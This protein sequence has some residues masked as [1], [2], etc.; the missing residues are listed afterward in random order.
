MSNQDNLQSGY[1]M[2]AENVAEMARLIRNAREISQTIG[3]CPKEITLADKQTILDIA[4]GPGEW[5]IEIAHLLPTSRIMGI[6]ISQIMTRYAHLT[7]QDQQL[8]NTQFRIMDATQPLDFP[9]SSFDL[10]HA[11]LIEGFL[12]RDDWPK[13]LADCF[14]LL[15]PGGVIC[16]VEIDNMGSNTSPA[17]THYNTLF[18]EALRRAGKS[19]TTSGDATGVLAVQARLLQNAGFTTIHSQAHS[20]NYSTGMPAHKTVYENFATMLQLLQPLITH[21][22]LATTEDLRRLRTLALEEMSAETFCGVMI[23][24][25]V[26]GEKPV[27]VIQA[28]TTL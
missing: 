2:D 3:L 14:R 23:L 22:K 17:L 28:Q 7:A 10:I 5:A 19:F 27:Q 20:F 8:L 25:S 13:L 4:C 11:R 26:W 6:D 12:S 1:M 9:D 16:T 24:Q 15:R 21:C 18:V